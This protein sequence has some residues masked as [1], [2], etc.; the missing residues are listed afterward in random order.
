MI[1]LETALALTLT[2][3]VEKK[4]LTAKQA[5]EKMTAAPAKI[6]NLPKGT[7]KAGSAA[8][9]IVVDPN[10]AWTVETARFASKSRN[11]P[12][13]GWQLKGKVIHTIVNGRIVV[14][15]GQL[16]V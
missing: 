4:V 9:V 3:L 10:L 12:F 6:L 14:R 15:D 8:D 13:G 5:L 16:V 1:G 7:L 2:E 11:S